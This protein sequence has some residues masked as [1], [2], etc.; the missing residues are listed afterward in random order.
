MT[1][2]AVRHHFGYFGQLN[3]EWDTQL[4]HE[5]LAARENSPSLKGFPTAGD[6]VNALARSG[7]N[8]AISDPILYSLI[9]AGQNGDH[10]ARRIVLQAMLGR[11][12]KMAYGQLRDALGTLDH[13]HEAVAIMWE[14]IVTYPLNARPHTIAGNLACDILKQATR[15]NSKAKGA[16]PALLGED[17]AP[18]S[19]EL[20]VNAWED[21]PTREIIDLLTWA[22]R[23]NVITQTDIQIVALRHL[24]DAEPSFTQIGERLGISADTANR[25]YGRAIAKLT[26]AATD[27]LS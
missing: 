4:K 10:Q 3:H 9:E 14:L 16:Q 21:S 25:R 18:G 23:T 1:T 19:D 13:E 6:V 17:A 12:V 24:V 26:R 20:V 8:R 22:M 15:K 11:C 2:T 7:G 27:Y 5:S